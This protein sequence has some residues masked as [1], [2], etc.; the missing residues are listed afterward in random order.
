MRFLRGG[1]TCNEDMESGRVMSVDALTKA[2]LKKVRMRYSETGKYM[3]A[4][5]PGCGQ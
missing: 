2:P 5:Y 3:K 1:A 4:K